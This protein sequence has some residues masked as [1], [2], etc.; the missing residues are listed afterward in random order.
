MQYN[1]KRTAATE[2]PLGVQ[3]KLCDFL[4]ILGLSTRPD[5]SNDRRGLHGD[6]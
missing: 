4:S 2:Q 5:A 3:T 6:A 1:K